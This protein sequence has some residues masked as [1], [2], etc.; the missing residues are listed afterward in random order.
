M[1]GAR[2]PRLVDTWAAAQWTGRA[3][4]T[5]YRWRSERRVTTY[6]QG[7]HALWDIDELPR[8]RHLCSTTQCVKGAGCPPLPPPP[9]LPIPHPRTPL[10]AA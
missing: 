4:G 10:D 9:P 8:Y 1:S 7:S 5:L 6:K 2:E 3:L